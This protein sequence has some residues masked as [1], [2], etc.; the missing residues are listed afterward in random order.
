[1]AA[2]EFALLPSAGLPF[3][4]AGGAR[5]RDCLRAG[6]EYSHRAHHRPIR[7]GHEPLPQGRLRG[8]VRRDSQ[9]EGQLL[10]PVWVFFS[11]LVAFS[12]FGSGFV[13]CLI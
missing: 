8:G 12:V 13:G 2:G 4:G 7:A 6:E 5:P 10:S 9:G 1:M 3:P 11:A